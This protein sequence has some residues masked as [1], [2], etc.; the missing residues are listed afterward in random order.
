LQVKEKGA[1]VPPIVM[2]SFSR[3]CASRGTNASYWW[4]YASAEGAIR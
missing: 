4:W 2:T 1:N 3:A